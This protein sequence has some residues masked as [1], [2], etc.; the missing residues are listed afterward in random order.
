MADKIVITST[1]IITALG[2][3]TDTNLQALLN[4]EAG[5]KHPVHLQTRY[6]NQFLM[7]E[8]DLSDKELATE[9]GLPTEDNGYTRTT[10]LALMAMKELMANTDKSVLKDHSFA[11][12]NAN[13]VGGMCSVEN[14]YLDFIS[15]KEEGYFTKYIDTLDC[16]ESTQNVCKYF[17]L[18]PFTATISTACSSSASAIMLGTRLI[19]QGVVD[20]A[21]CGGCDALSRFTLNGFHALKNVD[22]ELCRPF[23]QTRMGLNL[24]EAAG[25][26][27]LEKEEDAIARGANILGVL[28]GYSNTN[29]A[30][31]PTA[32][33]PEG[34]GALLTMQLALKKAGLTPKDIGYVNAH[35][36]ATF[37]NDESEGKALQQLF[38][39]DVPPFSS[40]KPYTGH[41]LAAAGAIEAIFSIWALQK[42]KALPNLNFKNKMEELN[43]TPNTEVTDTKIEHVLSNSFGFGGSNVSLIFSKA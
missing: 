31:H 37:N 6:A 35:G 22:K 14:M 36:T 9:L 12:I 15:D 42:Q 27:M 18:K 26:I 1:G 29:D 16:A 3:G 40:T 17:D 33:S 38:D 43:I 24:G 34:D 13:T 11:F 21:I 25:Y 8:I 10:L 19:Q 32:P 39:G 2:T 30:H 41:T 23:D 7:G 28:S 20:K 4:K 5:L